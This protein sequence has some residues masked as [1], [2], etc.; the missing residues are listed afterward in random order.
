MIQI[1]ELRVGNWV[2]MNL[3]E[4]PKNYVRVL[5]VGETMKCD[6]DG[7]IGYW[8]IGD[9]DPIPLSAEILL[10][11]GFK[12]LKGGKDIYAHPGKVEISV[13]PILQLPYIETDF[14]HAR[15]NGLRLTSLHKLQNLYFALTGEEL[16]YQP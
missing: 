7:D 6:D 9:F 12:K 15:I 8:N 4:L 16:N 14:G 2:G 13:N 1:T 10:A 11:C 3:K 5:E